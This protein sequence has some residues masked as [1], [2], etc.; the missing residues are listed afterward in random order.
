M[1]YPD[2]E[3]MRCLERPE[4]AFIS[5]FRW[6]AYSR[7]SICQIREKVAMLSGN[8]EAAHLNVSFVSKN[9]LYFQRNVGAAS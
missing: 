5:G 6:K 9:N 8:H 1:L 4:A 7:I 2:S 3:E